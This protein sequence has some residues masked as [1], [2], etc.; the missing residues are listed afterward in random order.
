MPMPSSRLHTRPMA[1]SRP[2]MQ[3]APA[4]QRASSGTWRGS[5]TREMSAYLALM[6][7]HA[8]D[9][10]RGSRALQ[11]CDEFYE[12]FDIQPGDGMYVAPED[13]VQIW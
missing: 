5:T 10:L 1:S 8:P 6:D 12:A 11:S 7:V 3:P 9:K 13:R 2:V 4:A